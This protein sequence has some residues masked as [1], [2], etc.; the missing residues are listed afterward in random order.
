MS[1][2]PYQ[3]V[4]SRRTDQIIGR[5]EPLKAIYNA[6]QNEGH[7]WL[8]YFY[9]DGGIGKTRLLEEIV[10][11]NGSWDG[12]SFRCTP[13]LDM[14]HSEYQSSDGIRQGI[15]AGLE[16][17]SDDFRGYYVTREELTA[18]QEAGV[19]NA[20]LQRLQDE[21]EAVFLKEYQ[22]LAQ[23]Q[24]LVIC[25][26]TMELM[27]HESD[28]VQ[29][30]CRVDMV[31]ALVMNWLVEQLPTLPNTVILM[32]GRPQN[33]E[34][35][36]SIFTEKFFAENNSF[37]AQPLQAFSLSETRQYLEAISQ[38][39][40]KGED[41]SLTEIMREHKG[42]DKQ[43]HQVTNGR[44]VYLALIIDLFLSQSVRSGDRGGFVNDILAGRAFS[45]DE[46][47]KQL[48]DT[49][50]ELPDPHGR[51]IQY[52]FCARKGLNTDLLIHFGVK[53][54]ESHLQ[55][56]EKLAIVKV[57]TVDRGNDRQKTYFFHDEVYNM[58]DQYFKN[59]PIEAKK[60]QPFVEYYRPKSLVDGLFYEL[61]AN[62]YEGYHFY[63]ARQDHD[64]IRGHERGYDMRLRNE[65]LGFLNR[66]VDPRSPFY[67]E[68][69][70]N[71]LNRNNV[72][73][74]CAVRWVRRHWARGD[75]KMAREVALDLIASDDPLFDWDKIDDD[76][77]KA[78]LLVALVEATVQEA[79]D[80]RLVADFLNQKALINV[81]E[82]PDLLKYAIT[83]LQKK[84]KSSLDKAQQWRYQ[85]ILGAAHNR[86]GYFYRTTGKYGQ[87]LFHYQQAVAHFHQANIKSEL[88]FA[89]TNTAYLLGLNSRTTEA[90]RLIEQ[91]IK[92]NQESK[93][94]YPLALALNTRGRIFTLDNHPDWGVKECRKALVTVREIGDNRG[95]GLALNGLGYSLRKQANQW[96]F[97]GISPEEA[98]LIFQEAVEI[99]NEAA[100][101]FSQFNEPVRLWEAYNELGS[102]YCDWGWLMRQQRTDQPKALE[103]YAQSIDYQ[104]QALNL[105]K[106]HKLESQILDSFDDLAQAYG[107]RSTLN[108]ELEN[109]EAAH[110]DR[111]QAEVYLNDVL[112]SI[113]DS[114][115]L[116]AGGFEPTLSEGE[117]QWLAM[118]K[119]HLWRGIWYF[120]DIEN[121]QV[122]KEEIE[123]R[124][125]KA[126]ENLFL[127]SIYFRQ[128]WPTSF[129]Y[130][131]TMGY[132]TKYL[133]R[134]GEYLSP[135]QQP[136]K[137]A[138]T[139]L[140]EIEDKYKIQLP[141]LHNLITRMVIL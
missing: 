114:F 58:Y 11:K 54:I 21:M 96:K 33:K 20:E 120:R 124:L 94:H 102:L 131:R 90:F 97:G 98:D 113:D 103:Y 130:D 118:G 77:Y 34:H 36:E 44:P 71:R 78:D 7:T 73:R 51:I 79:L 117:T 14:Y 116:A 37:E 139:H 122:L 125:K 39:L 127:S 28:P 50:R 69:I 89:L 15:V 82:I 87:A 5:E 137:W 128:Y 31:E 84:A 104:E 17:G 3:Q 19:S 115:K 18:K 101:I 4:P 35:I 49:L 43:L 74:D 108:I 32:A 136:T 67:D 47:A 140:E 138:E 93:R 6:I 99:L 88:A 119:L 100:G 105:A 135:S 65:A 8:L 62:P 109:I 59:D 134:I 48:I 27:Q 64:A 110:Q 106:E 91:A 23:K 66:Y 1:S 72:D 13:I 126:M 38:K 46:L 42:L 83:V 29:K 60:Y 22:A 10:T 40:E 16:E 52:L 26:D 68:L 24:R 121:K 55:W 45:Q 132:L 112:N 61:R 85:R 75:S 9:G 86:L 30:N 41:S 56:L 25:L 57:R 80:V 63:Y 81:K 141:E 92:L 129:D 76:F 107:D 95:A 70:A 123:N 53:D 2:N 111:E 133:P 12:L